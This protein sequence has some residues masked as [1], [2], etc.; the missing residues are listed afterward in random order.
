MVRMDLVCTAP[1]VDTDQHREPQR[2]PF[3]YQWWRLP[4]IRDDGCYTMHPNIPGE[5]LSWTIYVPDRRVPDGET[6]VIDPA[7]PSVVIWREEDRPSFLGESAPVILVRPRYHIDI[8]AINAPTQSW[9]PTGQE[10][11]EPGYYRTDATEPYSPPSF[12]LRSWAAPSEQVWEFSEGSNFEDDTGFYMATTYAFAQDFETVY[13]GDGRGEL[14]LSEHQGNWNLG[15]RVGPEYRW[16]INTTRW[17]FDAGNSNDEVMGLYQQREW[18]DEAK[19]LLPKPWHVNP[20]DPVIDAIDELVRESLEP[21]P[22]D[23][24]GEDRYDRCSR[25]SCSWHGL[26]CKGCGCE[27]SITEGVA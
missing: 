3:P 2:L 17:A 14:N 26:R 22:V 25:C 15:D 6:V 27:S 24:Y 11:F 13:L 7:P 16:D 12:P 23:D 20:E 4:L 19:R 18:V 10:F 21:G 5:P 8:V 9:E 1:A